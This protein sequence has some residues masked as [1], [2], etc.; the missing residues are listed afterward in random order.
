MEAMKFKFV[1]LLAL[2]TGGA[3]LTARE[4]YAAPSAI[5]GN[6]SITNPWNLF[7]ALKTNAIQPGD[8]LNLR[9]GTYTGPGFTSTL[10]GT[11]NNQITV[12]SYPGEWAILTDGLRPVLLS[13]ITRVPT[14]AANANVVIT[15]LEV[16]GSAAVG[17]NFSF[18]NDS[19]MTN[20]EGM[21]ILS[22]NSPT[23][24]YV[25]ITCRSTNTLLNHSPG[26]PFELSSDYLHDMGNYVTYRDFEISGHKPSRVL[27]PTNWVGAGFNM[28][29][30]NRGEKLI[31]LVIHNTGHPGIGAALQVHDVDAYEINGCLVFGTGVYYPW[32][33]M[34]P[35]GSGM[36]LENQANLADVKNCLI[37]KNFTAGAKFFGEGGDVHNQRFLTNISFANGLVALQ[38]SSGSKPS[39]NTWMNGNFMLGGPAL[40]YVS[41]SNVNQYFINNVVV[42]AS[43]GVSETYN[44]VY[45]NNTVFTRTNIY[46]S[47]GDAFPYK[48]YLIERTNLN[49]VWDYNTYYIGTGS[50]PYDFFFACKDVT[51]AQNSAGG[52][53]QR[54]NNDLGYSW[55]DWSATNSITGSFD[56]HSTYQAGWPTN[57]LNISVQRLDYDTSR[58]HIAVVST[59]G[60]TNTTIALS[61]YGFENGDRYRLVDAQNWPVVVASGTYA[62]GTINL[63]LNLT[64]VADIPGILFA[65][66]YQGSWVTNAH[67]NVRDPGLFNAF[68][69]RR[70]PRLA[71][72]GNLWPPVPH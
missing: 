8:T 72:P 54:F 50:N 32:N 4:W 61:D 14:N 57:Y 23:N 20:G 69:L 36:Y 45:T 3:G 15:G 65:P 25:L 9:G 70:I 34:Q 49:M 52:G 33:N 62:G 13:S 60:Q 68:E 39:S 47:G 67:T 16:M 10:N 66:P 12:R 28:A 44:S 11:N 18:A 7:L 48:C 2:I 46:G 6:G 71:P 1:L 31:N 53:W 38:I 5:S 21:Q 37:F 17:L 35:V 59:S 30:Q 55:L 64:N 41:V 63:P 22:R 27:T 56:A 40:S 26:E 51:N 58:W 42:N 29:N 19:G 24:F 43:F